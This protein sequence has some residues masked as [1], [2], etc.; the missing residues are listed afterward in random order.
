MSHD[1]MGSIGIC[2]NSEGVSYMQGGGSRNATGLGMLPFFDKPFGRYRVTSNIFHQ[3]TWGCVVVDLELVRNRYRPE[4]YVNAE[5]LV[6]PGIYSVK[7]FF[8]G[9]RDYKTYAEIRE[10]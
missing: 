7:K 8:Y 9:T 4:V 5:G 2:S 1:E 10:G 3:S 6:N